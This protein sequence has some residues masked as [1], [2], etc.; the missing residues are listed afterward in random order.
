VVIMASMFKG[1]N[2]FNQNLDRWNTSQVKRMDSMFQ[3]ATIFNQPL[4]S[5]CV[6]KVV[7]MN[8]MVRRQGIQS[9]IK[10]LGL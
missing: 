6:Q 5:W 7:N 3:G 2:R 1:A 9:A 8:S 10:R 4:K